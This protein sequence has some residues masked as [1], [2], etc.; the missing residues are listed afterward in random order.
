MIV[1]FGDGP[2]Y[3]KIQ[4]YPD[5]VPFHIFTAEFRIDD[6]PYIKI[7]DIIYERVGYYYKVMK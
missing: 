5:P 4:S 3:R 2:L 7:N 6:S 1:Y